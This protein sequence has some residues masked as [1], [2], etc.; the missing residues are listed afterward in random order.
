MILTVEQM[1]I[2]SR[3]GLD[4][5]GWQQSKDGPFIVAHDRQQNNATYSFPGDA[6]PADILMHTIDKRIAFEKGKD[7]LHASP[8]PPPK[9]GDTTKYT[10][11]IA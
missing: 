1:R 3:L 10:K 11:G 2:L 8:E 6:A 4:F 9:E 7:S 5:G